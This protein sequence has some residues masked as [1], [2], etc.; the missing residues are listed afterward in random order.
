MYIE[1][2]SFTHHIKPMKLFTLIASAA[3]IGAS[4]LVPN[5]AEAQFLDP[6]TGII[7]DQFGVLQDI[8]PGAVLNHQL[9]LRSDRRYM[10][11]SGTIY[12]GNRLMIDGPDPSRARFY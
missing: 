4:F 11:N 3:V 12:D 10:D 6:T 9:A 1:A 8:D 7:T 5:P 2:M